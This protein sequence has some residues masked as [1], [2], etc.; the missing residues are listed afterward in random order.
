MIAL[1]EGGIDTTA[2]PPEQAVGEYLEKV[3]SGIGSDESL[4]DRN[5]RLAKLKAISNRLGEIHN[6]EIRDILASSITHEEKTAKVLEKFEEYW[7]H[8]APGG[9]DGGAFITTKMIIVESL[10]SNNAQMRDAV[11]DFVI[12]K[13]QPDDIDPKSINDPWAGMIPHMAAA[14][15]QSGDSKGRRDCSS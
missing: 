7:K 4:K 8:F 2:M 9:Y 13:I 11:T 6:Q 5:A 3:R 15:I 12:S 1:R 14:Y 10:K